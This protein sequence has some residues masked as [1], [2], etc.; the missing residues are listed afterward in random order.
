MIFKFEGMKDD[1]ISQYN[2][3]YMFGMNFATSPQKIFTAISPTVICQ[4]IPNTY[5]RCKVY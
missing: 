3:N 2:L 4:K 1:R 5:R